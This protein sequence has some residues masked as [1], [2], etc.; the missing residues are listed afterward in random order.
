MAI[1]VPCRLLG[2]LM[3]V[4]ALAGCGKGDQ[5]LTVSS[6]NFAENEIL[7]EMFAQLAEAK[8]IRVVR[9]LGLGDARLNLEA[10]KRGEIDLYPEYNGT[11]LVLLGQPP[12][13]DGDAMMA[14]LRELYQ[15]LGLVWG[16]RL[17][18]TDNYGLVMRADRARQLGITTISDLVKKAGQLSIG[19]EDDFAKRP[20]DGYNALTR[21]Y[22]LDFANETTLGLAQR[23]ELYDRLIDGKLDVVEGFTTDGQ[24]ADY[25][26]V[27][28]KDDL[29]FFP[30]YQAVPLLRADA[31][32]RFP[33]LMP[34]LDRLGGRIDTDRM[35]RLN[36]RVDIDGE[37]ARA[38]ARSTLIELGLIDGAT[39]TAPGTVL[40]M[41]LPA[42]L[43]IET[44]ARTLRAVRR[45]FAGQQVEPV[46]EP[47]PLA[48]VAAGRA[49]LALAPAA[50]FFTLGQGG[51]PMPRPGLQA[52][53]MVGD[54]SLQVIAAA[55][56][57]TAIAAVRRL[58]VGPDGSI[59]QLIG[60]MLTGGLGL[61]TTLV[62]AGD[63][64][65]DALAAALRDGQ[66]DAALALSAD[67]GTLASEIAG[68]GGRIL[69]LDGWARGTNLV[70]YPFLRQLRLPGGIETLSTQL[71]LAGPGPAPAGQ[72]TVGD[73]GP[74]AV[75]TAKAQPLADATVIAL[76]D[77][78]GSR[79][80]ID[81]ILPQAA[82]L[83]PTLAPPPA[84]IN[85]A[86]DVAV[87]DALIIAMLI[88]LMW[89]Y[90]RP[91]RR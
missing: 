8:G 67:D 43:G 35:R 91:E 45:A 14:R 3:L 61:P 59:S 25:G 26:F 75:F 87:I 63:G 23:L 69:G 66:A 24:I 51:G 9:R 16:Q 38:V 58:A 41:A 7:G 34:Q 28:L 79:I 83:A 6:K 37:P 27:V 19:I 32:S 13:G 52:V 49:R 11:G 77:A 62:P 48:A 72:V 64:S 70:R 89:L 82:A 88:W 17:G 29:G 68:S 47:D 36:M 5:P 20:L 80:E 46:V 21:R 76:R 71:V 30:V 85:P 74:G 65:R 4:L 39:K 53:G 81:P 78:L 2:V 1:A 73:Q 42:T 31:A 86:P 55:N 57:P 22:G 10:L 54:A 12:S 18:L 15:P 33:Q 44:R 84:A 56:G 40:Q 60:R 90:V 50:G